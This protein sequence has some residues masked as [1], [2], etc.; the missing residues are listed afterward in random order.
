MGI[1]FHCPKG[2]K[3]NVKAF[4]AGKKGVCP[5]CG[6]KF[7]IPVE[8]EPTLRDSEV[9][10]T[11]SEHIEDGKAGNG[12]AVTAPVAVAA[13]TAV[14]PTPGGVAVSAP[15]SSAAAA[16]PP[17]DPIAEAPAAI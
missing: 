7:R 12:A 13:S 16:A 17:A 6:A 8:S 9:E 1:K 5:K 2:H 4:L 3:L 15:S 11:E 10:E 14:P